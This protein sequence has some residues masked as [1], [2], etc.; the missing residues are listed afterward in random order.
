M[1]HPDHP[2]KANPKM[3]I[4]LDPGEEHILK[5][6]TSSGEFCRLGDVSWNFKPIQ[7]GL[8]IFRKIPLGKD[9]LLKKC[10]EQPPKDLK[11]GVVQFRYY[12]HD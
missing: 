10:M 6:E 9:E 12:Q 5:L 8:R 11:K 4:K 1:K 2:G 3:I 7:E